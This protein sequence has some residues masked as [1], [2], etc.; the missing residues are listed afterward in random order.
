MKVYVVSNNWQFDSGECGEEISTFSTLDK[1]RKELNELIK[2]ARV[3][4]SD[5][6]TE[7]EYDYD[8]NDNLPLAFSI[9][10]EGEY[11]YNHINIKIY[12]C[13]IL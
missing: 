12:E 2:Q 10:E 6:D 3:D 8:L 4:I 11:C 1:A 5:F 9:W 7:E 13:E